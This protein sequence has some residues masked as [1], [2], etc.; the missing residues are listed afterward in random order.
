G[1][2]EEPPDEVTSEPDPVDR[3][4]QDGSGGRSDPVVEEPAPAPVLRTPYSNSITIPFFRLPAAGEIPA[5]SLPR[6]SSFYTTIS[7]PVPTL[8]EF[9]R[10][11]Q[12]VPAPGPAPGPQ[13]R[14]QEEAPVADATTGTITGS[15]GGSGSIMSEPV[16][17]H[18]PLVTVPRAV[19][20]AGRPPRTAGGPAGAAVPPGVTQPG[21]AGVRT[22]T[23]RG[24]VAPTPGVSASPAATPRGASTTVGANPRGVMNPTVAEIAA[25]AA[26]GVAGLLLLTFSGGL[27][28]YRQANSG[29]YVRTAG[30]E[31]FL[32]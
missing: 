14:T 18:A 9:L 26:P 16:V 7:I 6:V 1:A 21:V 24:S 27:I 8:G 5:G 30:A 23:I 10:S 19:T 11:L 4:E 31:R 15:G 17:F 29:R 12:S 32:P 22:A 2:A 25:V 28:G 13:F 20:I 3:V